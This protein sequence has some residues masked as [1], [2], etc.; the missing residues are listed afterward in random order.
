MGNVETTATVWAHKHGVIDPQRIPETHDFAI[1]YSANY[2]K[3]VNQVNFKSSIKLI[4][5]NNENAW[6]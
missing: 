1:H 4:Y 2:F 3:E 5:C 6:A